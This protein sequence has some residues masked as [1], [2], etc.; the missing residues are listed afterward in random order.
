[1]CRTERLSDTETPP[2]HRDWLV[3]QP[4][5]FDF[6]FPSKFSN[7]SPPSLAS[8]S[9]SPRLFFQPCDW[10][11]HGT[12]LRCLAAR[13]QK[14]T[15]S[16]V[17]NRYRLVRCGSKVLSRKSGG[18]GL[19]GEFQLVGRVRPQQIIDALRPLVVDFLWRRRLFSWEKPPN[20]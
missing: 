10:L 4:T 14:H 18:L 15:V 12:V 1:M 7:V 2:S 6:F 5:R 17:A 16:D 20:S 19:S 3:T 8:R 11:R 9:E 13:L